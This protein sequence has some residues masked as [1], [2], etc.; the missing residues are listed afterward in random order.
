MLAEPT[1]SVPLKPLSPHPTDAAETAIS[2]HGLGKM[3]RIY[4]RPQDRL[5]EMLFWRLGKSYGRDFWALRNVSFEVRK[6]EAVGIIGR[7]GSGKSTLLQIITGTL[8]PTAGEVQ[9]SG[10]VAAL[11]EL[12]SGF[13]PEFTGRENV[14]LNGAIL[15]IGRKEME[16]RFDEIAAFADIGTFIDQ[17]VKTYSSGMMVRLAFALQA[18]VE[19]DILII[20]EALA[21]GDIFFRQKC[22][23]RLEDLRARGVSILLVSH[24]M[25][26]IE[27]LCERAMLL[28]QGETFFQGAASEA[29][30]RYY[31][32]DQHERL[33]TQG[34]SLDHVLS[35]Q[36]VLWQA[37]EDLFWPPSEA[38]LDIA[39]VAQVSNGWA[40]CTGVALCDSYGQP[41]HVFEQ[42]E[43]ASFFYEFELLQAI[44]VPIGGVVLQNEK[45][46]IVHGKN[47]L[48]YGSAVPSRIPQGSRIRFQQEITLEIAPGEYT[49]EV[50]LAALSRYI[51]DNLES[52]SLQELYANIVR[53]CHLPTITKFAIVLRRGGR[54]IELLH[55]G[56]A[57]LP[58]RCR[59]HVF[60]T[61]NSN[62]QTQN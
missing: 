34:V 45:G 37:D 6:G 51:Y 4:N 57:N 42:G 30:K 5:K 47:T 31:L 11:L 33:A 1:T 12:G 43:T 62:G 60:G 19:P 15:G 3:Y 39:R 59:A 21:V 27:Q 36:D 53:L 44:D 23:Q 55:H 46:V 10:R 14:F 40:R 17:P 7:N 41:C 48:Q 26:D 8:A 32:I 61:T 13:K 29:V 52:Y 20:D 54:P 50:G 56:M 24:S 2:V 18:S 28:D 22:Y 38:F 9:V 58:G 49:F 25:P 16:A 35:S